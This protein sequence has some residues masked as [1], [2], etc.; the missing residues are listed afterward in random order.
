M[1]RISF[2]DNS[3]SAYSKGGSFLALLFLIPVVL[4]CGGGVSAPQ[5][6]EGSTVDILMLFDANIDEKADDDVKAEHQRIADWMQNDLIQ[7]FEAG[8]YRVTMTDDVTQFT[9]GKGK[10]LL[11]VKM[12]EFVPASATTLEERGFGPGTTIIDT[13]S[14]LFKDNHTIP[15]F[16]LKKGHVSAMKWEVCAEEVTS[17]V[18]KDIS[19]TINELY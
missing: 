1:N 16:R 8:G 13:Y 11:V 12:S 3:H 15:R 2:F 14:E 7:R 6:P 5:T 18:A 9:P 17:N 19:K 4:G 10:F